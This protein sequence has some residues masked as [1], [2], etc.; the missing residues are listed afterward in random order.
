MNNLCNSFACT[1]C[2]TAGNP[3]WNR[4]PTPTSLWWRV[5]NICWRPNGSIEVI[6]VCSDSEKTPDSV[7]RPA[8]NKSPVRPPADWKGIPLPCLPMASISPRDTYPPDELHNIIKVLR[9][10]IADINLTEYTEALQ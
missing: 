5:C 2:S 8:L 1:V 4:V 7:I 9:L 10:Q 6:A 3:C